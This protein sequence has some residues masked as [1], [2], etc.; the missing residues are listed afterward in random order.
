MDEILTALAE[1]RAARE[2]FFRVPPV[3]MTTTERFPPEVWTR[4]GNAEDRLMTI[5][6]E[7]AS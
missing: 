4:L 3:P 2:A 6:R 7:V 1:W 5:A